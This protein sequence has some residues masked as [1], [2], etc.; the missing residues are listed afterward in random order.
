MRGFHE[1][2][3]DGCCLSQIIDSTPEQLATFRYSELKKIAHMIKELKMKAD[4]GAAG[5]T[6]C[7]S[8]S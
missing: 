1:L 2:W 3:F 7:F 5:I 8:A 6:V 4:L